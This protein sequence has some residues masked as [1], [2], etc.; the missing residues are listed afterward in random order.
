MPTINSPFDIVISVVLDIV[1]VALL[2]AAHKTNVKLPAHWSGKF[3]IGGVCSGLATRFQVSATLIRII[4]VFCAWAS[5]GA[6]MIF[7][8]FL[9]WVTLPRE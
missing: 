1:I 8:Y 2:Y 9:L 7:L 5:G 6:H 3:I 4:V